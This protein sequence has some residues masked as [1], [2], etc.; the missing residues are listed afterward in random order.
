[1]K[2]KSTDNE[3]RKLSRDKLLELLLVQN[4]ELRELKK[5]LSGHSKET[6]LN[7]RVDDNEIQRLLERIQRRSRV[8]VVLRS[9]LVIFL[10]VA[11]VT[12]LIATL[13]MPVLRIYGQS[14]SPTFKNGDIVVSMKESRFKQGEIVAFYYNNKILVKRAIA[15]AGDWVDL[16]EDGTVSVNNKVMDE[17]YIAKEAYGETNIEFPY[18][19]PEGKIFVM[20]DN[21]ELS[22][23][24]RSTSIGCVSEEQLVGKLIFRV[25]P[26]RSFGRVK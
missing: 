25:W 24:S 2:K 9:I 15:Q 11:S 22:I 26:L 1:M 3:L 23:D 17:P 13:W 14:M 8:A 12:V 21:R 16:D 6:I 5:E 10:V 4:K 7:E 18:Q 19:V 20:G